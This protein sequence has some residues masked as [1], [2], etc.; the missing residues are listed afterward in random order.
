MLINIH[1]D[2]CAPH[3]ILQI[4]PTQYSSFCL[5]DSFPGIGGKRSKAL[6]E[7]AVADPNGALD[8]TNSRRVQ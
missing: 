7:L 8:V 3:S 6:E 4:R 5:V 1:K 2:T